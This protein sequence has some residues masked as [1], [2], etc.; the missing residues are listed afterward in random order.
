MAFSTGGV[1]AE[2]M[3]VEIQCGYP[4]GS[5][6]LVVGDCTMV[7]SISVGTIAIAT[8]AVES[9]VTLLRDQF[10]V[11][12]ASGA[13]DSAATPTGITTTD[14]SGSLV[15][16]TLSSSSGAAS[17][18]TANGSAANG[19]GRVAAT[20]GLGSILAMLSIGFIIA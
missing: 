13:D 9:G 17:T 1:D 20:M 14:A 5:D 18:T 15:T 19:A 8:T 2:N 4:S 16:V 7:Q 3:A 12:T 11:S 6:S 10:S